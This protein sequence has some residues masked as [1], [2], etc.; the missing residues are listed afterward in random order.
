MRRKSQKAGKDNTPFTGNCRELVQSEE[1][2]SGCITGAMN[3][4]TFISERGK[5]RRLTPIECER[6]QGFEDNWTQYGMN[7]K[8]SDSQRYKMLGN[9]V[10]VNV[11][12]AIVERLK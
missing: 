10:T 2:I 12:E 9:A 1:D 3:K 8:I 11:I 4:D 5:I 7:G 6:L